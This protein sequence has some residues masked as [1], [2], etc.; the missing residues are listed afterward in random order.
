MGDSP[1]AKTEQADGISGFP[2]GADTT[3]G[4]DRADGVDHRGPELGGVV[5]ARAGR[6]STSRSGAF[7]RQHPPS[8][9]RLIVAGPARLSRERNGTVIKETLAG[10]SSTCPVGPPVAPIGIAR[11]NDVCPR[12]LL[13][14]PLPPITASHFPQFLAT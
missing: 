5:P 14:S 8:Y 12:A 13:L 10:I 11:P 9:I 4:K 6:D 7:A 3:T 1:L 2:G